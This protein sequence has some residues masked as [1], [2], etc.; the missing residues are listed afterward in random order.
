MRK[1]TNLFFPLNDKSTI[2]SLFNYFHLNYHI[3][4]IFPKN[5]LN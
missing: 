3:I 2:Q 5:E 1:Y 4:N